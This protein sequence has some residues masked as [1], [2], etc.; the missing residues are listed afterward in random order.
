MEPNA[1]LADEESPGKLSSNQINHKIS[2]E[3]HGFEKINLFSSTVLDVLPIQVVFGPCVFLQS[4][5]SN[6]C[7][8]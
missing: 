7:S 8:T 2:Q 3:C 1:H 4:L 6:L 5:A